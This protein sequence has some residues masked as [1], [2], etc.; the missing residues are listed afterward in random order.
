M[1]KYFQLLWQINLSLLTKG[2]TQFFLYVHAKTFIN[3]KKY[4]INR[5]YGLWLCLTILH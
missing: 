3:L 1:Q 2:C 5:L 4:R